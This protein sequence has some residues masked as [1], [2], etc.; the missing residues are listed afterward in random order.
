MCVCYFYV[1]ICTLCFFPYLKHLVRHSIESYETHCIGVC[2]YNLFYCLFLLFVLLLLY[3]YQFN[4][5]IHCEPW[6]VRFALFVKLQRRTLQQFCTI[7]TRFILF[8]F[9]TLRLW[10]WLKYAQILNLKDGYSTQT[11]ATCEPLWRY[12]SDGR[13][14][15]YL[16]SVE[17]PPIGWRSNLLFAQTQKPGFSFRPLKKLFIINEKKKI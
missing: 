12:L 1:I 7:F 3:L 16:F 6:G 14:W 10:C 2:G 8:C 11:F 13:V 5:I 17:Y 9:C 4:W 15:M